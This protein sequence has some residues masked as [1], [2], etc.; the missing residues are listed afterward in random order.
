MDLSAFSLEGKAAIVTGAGRGIGRAIAVAF[1]KAGADVVAA[2]RTI[3]QIEETADL[4]RREGRQ[5]LAVPT[6][7][8]KADRIEEMLQK[9]L[10]SF[11]KVD[12]LV[13]CAGGLPDDIPPAFGSG[14][15]L[16]VSVEEWRSEI[17][18]NLNSL[19]YCCKVVG[20]H[21]VEQKSGVIINISSGMGLGPFP[22]MAAAAAARAAVFNFTK[23][24]AYE[25][26]PYNIRVNCLAPGFTET[27]LTARDWEADPTLREALLKNIAHGRFAKPEEMATICTFLAS[28][29]ASYVTGET[30][31]ASGGMMSLLPPGYSEY[32]K[33]A[34]KGQ[35]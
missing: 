35:D 15:I 34:R 12:I 2:A 32:V 14:Y 22:G 16:N 26:A 31:F 21:M 6:D 19:F 29:A 30:I 25:W 7:V 4:V 11:R 23:T 10:G 20:R 8:L 27:P 28:P 9:T 1:A 5:A 13:N 17:E 24:L 18:L 33:Q 3:G